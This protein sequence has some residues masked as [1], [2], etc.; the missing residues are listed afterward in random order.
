MKITN[1]I[2]NK[3]TYTD[4][5][6]FITNAETDGD[7]IIFE[8][9]DKTKIFLSPN[10]FGEIDNIILEDNIVSITETTNDE[11]EDVIKVTTKNGIFFLQIL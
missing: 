11:C 4:L 7:Y 10:D 5:R 6:A 9:K 2:L 1:G 8:E 3:L